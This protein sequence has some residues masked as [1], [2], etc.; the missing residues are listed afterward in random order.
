MKKKII[1]T[2]SVIMLLIILS[3]IILKLTYTIPEDYNLILTNNMS[4]VDGPDKTYYIYDDK[5]IVETKSYFP[6]GQ[7]PFGITQNHTIEIF[8]DEN[9]VNI[10]TLNGVYNLINNKDGK[11]VYNV[12]K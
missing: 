5:I 10:N 9:A 6:S 11:T 7:Y 4:H 3:F 12:W 8:N 2:I 1:I